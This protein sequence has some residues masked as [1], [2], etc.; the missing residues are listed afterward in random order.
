MTILNPNRIAFA[1]FGA[2]ALATLA[3][4][5]SRASAEPFIIPPPKTDIAANA[6]TSSE[7]KSIVLAGG[8]F[9]GVQ[10]VYQHTKGVIQAVSGYAGGPADSARYDTVST[11]STGHAESVKITYNPKEISLGKILQIYFSVVHD[12]TQLNRQGPDSGTQYRSAIFTSQPEEQKVVKDYIAELD[13]A[14]VYKKPI[15]TKIEPMNGFY[16]A[17]N[18]HQDYLTLHPYQP[19]IAF[20]DIPKVDNLKKLFAADYRD[21]PVLVRDAK[22]TN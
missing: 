16:P 11:G 8:C 2:L 22:A 19:Y 20:N 9:W 15:V 7:P 14:K 1:A 17:E 6:A 13:A 10:G 5:S 3:G 4:M 12:P 18:Y 21:K